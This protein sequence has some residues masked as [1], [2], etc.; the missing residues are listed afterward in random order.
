MPLV[1]H[2]QDFLQTIV[3][4][5]MQ[6]RNLYDDAVMRQTLH[7]RIRQTL[8][9]LLTIVVIL[10]MIHIENRFLDVTHTM[11]QQVNCHHRQTVTGRIIL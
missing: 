3:H 10:L 4:L 5:T 1:E 7:K 2:I 9:Y 11:A 8:G 6:Q